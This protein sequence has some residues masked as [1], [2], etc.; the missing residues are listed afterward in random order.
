MAGSDVVGEEGV[1]RNPMT[2]G[3]DPA[4]PRPCHPAVEHMTAFGTQASLSVLVSGQKHE[5]HFPPRGLKP[6]RK[7]L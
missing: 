7:L 2:P 4:S 3:D 5:E 1:A 6:A